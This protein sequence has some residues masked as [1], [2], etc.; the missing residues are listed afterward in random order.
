MKMIRHCKAYS[1]H[2]QQHSN[3]P[4]LSFTTTTTKQNSFSKRVIHKLFVSFISRVFGKP[5]SDIRRRASMENT[6]MDEKTMRIPR[7]TQFNDAI[8][9]QSTNGKYQRSGN[10]EISKGK[11]RTSPS[12][13][14]VFGN[15]FGNPVQSIV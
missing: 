6:T 8:E 11:R 15:T 13:L 3:E 14:K 4:I 5:L 12:F 2:T 1:H 10:T 7:N 9:Y